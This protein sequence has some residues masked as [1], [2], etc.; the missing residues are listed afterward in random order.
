[1]KLAQASINLEEIG[2]KEIKPRRSR[3]GALLLEIPGTEG[4]KLADVLADRMKEAL[5]DKEGVLISRP[6]K[7][8]E[9][10]VRDLEDS[11]S[12]DEIAA[13]MAIK[14]GCS[15]EEIKVGPTRPATN[16]LGTI[17]V[18][19]PL[20]AAGEIIRGGDNK[21]WLDESESGGI[22][23]TPIEVFQMPPKRTREGEMLK[24]S[25]PIRGLL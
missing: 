25:G 18:R 21:D 4:E 5:A 8:A 9:I 20:K 17:W 19:F 13:A 24:R 23:G 11:V 7:T 12:A 16:G 10:R 1:M 22:G 3:T 15:P 6:H 14:G 2:I